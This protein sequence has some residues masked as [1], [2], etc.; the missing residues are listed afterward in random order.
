M[1]GFIFLEADGITSTAFDEGSGTI[2][3]TDVSCLGFESRLVDCPASPVGD[4]NCDHSKDA[5]VLCIV[6][7]N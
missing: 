2:H 1:F 4:R 3:L 5:G 6:A 7:S